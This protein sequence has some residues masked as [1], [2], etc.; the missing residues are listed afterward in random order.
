MYI[1]VYMPEII[2]YLLTLRI[3]YMF[4][5]CSAHYLSHILF[6]EFKSLIFTI[7]KKWHLKTCA[8]HRRLLVY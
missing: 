8:L 2:L 1:R 7:T 3:S 6:V 4:L 5:K